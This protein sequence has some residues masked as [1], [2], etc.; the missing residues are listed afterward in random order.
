MRLRLALLPFSVRFVVTAALFAVFWGVTSLMSRSLSGSIPGTVFSALFFGVGLA[1]LF[2]YRGRATYKALTE[3]VAGL[4][5]TERSQAIAAVTHGVVPT[6]PTVRSSAIRL[7]AACL[8]GT[9]ADQLK[10]QERHT[11]MFLGFLVALCI[12]AVVMNFNG[13][14]L[15]YLALALFLVVVL[16]LGPRRTRRI[17]RIQRNVALLSEDET[18][19]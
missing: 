1:A 6:D 18:S 8:G 2:S 9:S 17:Q 3:A 16:A 12:A 15:L 7:G 11:W 14:R 13:D 4:D 5:T 19:R 10:R